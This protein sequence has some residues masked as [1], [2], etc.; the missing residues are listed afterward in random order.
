MSFRDDVARFGVKLESQFKELH[1]GVCDLAYLSIVEGSPVTGAPGQRVDTGFMKSSW[2]NE[3]TG[4][5][6][7]DI[8]TNVAYAP[9]FEDGTY[10]PLGVGRPLGAEK[11]PGGTNRRGPSTVGGDHSVKLT[12]AGWPRIVET[13]ALEVGRGR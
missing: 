11:L 4:P 6:T 13:V 5:L 12:I 9:L 8:S 10:N 2:Q 3:V 1:N 7:R